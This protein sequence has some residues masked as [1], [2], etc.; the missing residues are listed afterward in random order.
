MAH[1]APKLFSLVLD[2]AIGAVGQLE[3]GC[4][5]LYFGFRAHAVHGPLQ[6]V[7]PV[8]LVGAVHRLAEDGDARSA[9]AIELGGHFRG[10][11]LDFPFA[12]DEVLGTG[13]ACREQHEAGRC[14]DTQ[15]CISVGLQE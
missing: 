8:H 7:L 14:H 12:E 13:G 15:L 9:V 1:A 3:L 4:G 5:H 10:G 6:F 11:V 2:G